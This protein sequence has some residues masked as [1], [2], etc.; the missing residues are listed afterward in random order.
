MLL[1]AGGGGPNWVVGGAIG[2][3]AAIAAM[4]FAAK[5]GGFK[6]FSVVVLVMLGLGGF[7]QTVC[8]T[9]FHSNKNP[10]TDHLYFGV[11]AVIVSIV[12]LLL[13]ARGFFNT[14]VEESKPKPATS[15]W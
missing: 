9:A 3:S 14:R 10:T 11:V 13:L 1:M 2:A 12:S 15:Q 7:A 8:G 6:T 5:N 4:V